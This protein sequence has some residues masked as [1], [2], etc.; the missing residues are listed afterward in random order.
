MTNLFGH[1]VRSELLFLYLTETL[2][3][4]LAVYALMALGMTTGPGVDYGRLGLL[5]GSLALCTGLVASASGLYQPAVM[6]H[7]R[8]MVLC[9]VVAAVP[10]SAVAWL[11]LTLIAPSGVLAP[12]LVVVATVV[13]SSM[14]AVGGT[15]LAHA[16]A[17]R[18]GLLT[19]RLLIIGNRS[20][21]SPEAGQAHDNAVAFLDESN[22][23]Q[24]FQPGWLRDRHIW[25]VVVPTG[26][27][28]DARLVQHCRHSS[29][30]LL[31]QDQFRECKLNRV[32]YEGLP[33]N[34]LAGSGVAR[35]TRLE[36]FIRRGF[37]IFVALILLIVTL[38]VWLVAA[39]LVKL[40]SKGPVFYR[41]ERCGIHSRPF[42]LAKFRS[43]RVDAEAAGAPVWATK[44]DSRVTRFGRFMRLTRIDELPQL[45][46]VLRGDMAIVGPR[47]ERPGFVRQ[48]AEVI[49]HYDDRALVKPGITGWAQV[50]YPYGASVEDA[51]MKLAYD[52]YYVSRRSLFLDMVI[53][54]ATVRVVLFQEGAR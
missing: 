50:N 47:P 11:A 8:R 5:A 54:V 44:Q 38:P 35:Q 46:N 12:T 51:R 6:Q 43:M 30:R 4:F 7:R 25:A 49:P 13:L 3:V 18:H 32:A 33:A 23:S 53:L 37:D 20:A 36:Q 19:R 26:M 9:A 22:L 16:A 28:A 1:E 17:L 21:W 2:A 31:N 15:R 24:A 27:Q 29:V 40:D 48:L 41:Q 42:M 10:L 34:W 45:F 52:L 39:I 14:L